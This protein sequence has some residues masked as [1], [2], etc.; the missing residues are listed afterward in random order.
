MR[1][2]RRSD[3]GSGSFPN[4]EI[5]PKRFELHFP[6]PLKISSCINLHVG[7]SFGAMD[8]PNDLITATLGRKLLGISPNKMRDLLR[9]G[10]LRYFPDPLDN[11]KKLVS[12]S[13]V[14]A[15]KMPRAEAA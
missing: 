1:D 14:L 8:I 2:C 15:L 5:N 6:S 9:D 7:V 12:K 13:E 3:S 4:L 11:R 10:L